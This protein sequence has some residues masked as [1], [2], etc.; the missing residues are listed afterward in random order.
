MNRPC[1]RAVKCPGQ[2][3]GLEADSPI[4]NFSSEYNDGVEFVSYPFVPK[5]PYDPRISAWWADSCT[6]V[7]C[8]STVSQ[9]AADDCASALAWLCVSIPPNDPDPPAPCI[10]NPSLCVPT[11]LGMVPN[12]MQ[13]A[14][15]T[16]PDGSI[17]TWTVNAGTIYAPTQG[18]ANAVALALAE[19]RVA[20]N[21]ICMSSLTNQ[22]C[23]GIEYTDLVVVD[24]GAFQA[25][26]FSIV[27][28]DLPPGLVLTDLGGNQA[29]ITGIA[30]IT[31]NYI[32]TIRATATNGNTAERTYEF[33]VMGISNASP[34]T[35]AKIGVAYSQQLNVTGG[36]AP[37]TF[38]ILSGSLPAGLTISSSG[39]ISGTPTVIGNNSFT[40]LF[41]DSNGGT[42]TKAFELTVTSAALDW[43]KLQW[44]APVISCVGS[45]TC[46]GSAN[47]AAPAQQSTF[48]VST[49]AVTPVT[50]SD[51][52]IEATLVYN[53]PAVAAVLTVTTSGWTPPSGNG[54]GV[55]SIYV[56]GV[57]GPGI[58]LGS[59]V[60]DELTPAVVPF[61]VPDTGGVNMTLHVSIGATST[62]TGF[63]PITAFANANIV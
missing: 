25:Y 4:T 43:T 31:G 18:Q 1:S 60:A 27:A 7:R 6:G 19:K 36:V 5:N 30:S 24:D 8:T 14:T 29:S 58:P 34:L 49:Q 51:S 53:G 62:S 41:L 17:F 52:T 39:L 47:P 21:F 15:F 33:S 2:A 54:Q 57:G 28:G 13:Q 32:A 56:W 9:Q 40:V 38:S 12:Q 44:G 37:F 48:G 42:C 22:P 61:V 16:C 46:V 3:P 50:Q 26:T 55:W 20:E 63:V 35:E 23:L 11:V 59:I 10:T 45:G